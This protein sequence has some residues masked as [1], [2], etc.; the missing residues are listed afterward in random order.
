MNLR[1]INYKYDLIGLCIHQG[2][3]NGG[4]YY[5]IC[6]NIE[7]NQWNIHNDTNVTPTTIEDIKNENP[8]CFFYVKRKV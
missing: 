2:S 5:A 1:N 7:D 4:H 3:L 6:K 8:Y